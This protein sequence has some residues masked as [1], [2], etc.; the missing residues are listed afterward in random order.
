MINSILNLE[1][2]ANVRNDIISGSMPNRITI[3]LPFTLV[4]KIARNDNII[5]TVI[6]PG[7]MDYTISPNINALHQHDHFELMYVLESELTHQIEN[8]YYQYKKGDSCL[9]N[10]NI[11]HSE[12][13]GYNCTV[14][15]IN[16]SDQYIRE[17]LSQDVIHDAH[18]NEQ[19]SEGKIR[20]FI[21]S[22]LDGKERYSRNYMEF[23]ST[24]QALSKKETPPME[25]IIDLIQQ[26]MIEQK[27]GSSFM[28]KGLLTR[29]IHTLEDPT[30]YHTSL[31][32]L[33]S[34]SED[35][36]FARITNY[37][38]ESNGCISRTELSKALNY[39]AEYLNQIVKKRTGLS[40]LQLGKTYR[41]EKAKQ[42]L[43]QTDE[44]IATIIKELG[45]VSS[46]H[47]YK[48]FQKE[49]G[50]SPNEYR[51]QKSL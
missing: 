12:V 20:Q 25:A 10:R 11:H 34:S 36:L 3:S 18:G 44:S 5:Y 49:T 14:V 30:K 43:I 41:L 24:L 40:M 4:Y 46:S 32:Q 45:F 27:P 42:L 13:P 17:I 28:L 23:N 31:M 35:F 37:L 51:N 26:E 47:F 39:N 48:F 16:F 21:L 22:N 7:G 9:L 38:K 33:D 2:A 50:L 15:F 1:Q 19:L 29:L 8:T 6:Y